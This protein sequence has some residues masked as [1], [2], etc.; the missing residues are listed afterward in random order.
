MGKRTH[1]KN[2]AE[3]TEKKLLSRKSQEKVSNSTWNYLFS[4]GFSC[5]RGQTRVKEGIF[6]IGSCSLSRLNSPETERC[7]LYRIGSCD[8]GCRQVPRSAGWAGKLESQIWWC[9]STLE[10]SRFKNQE[11]PRFQFESEGR[12]R[13]MF[14]FK[15]CQVGGILSYSGEI[16]PFYSS[17]VFNW[18]D[19]AHSH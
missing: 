19:E 15:V 13:V 3:D 9:S 1:T 11:E 17:K 18:L 16:Q 14:Q 7:L 2:T 8:Y 4:F 6:L 5:R 12:I 10:A